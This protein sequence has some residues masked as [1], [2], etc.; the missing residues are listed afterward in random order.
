MSFSWRSLT[1]HG[2]IKI[3]S[4]IEVEHN[5]SM[6]FEIQSVGGGI[7][8]KIKNREKSW[9][10]TGEVYRSLSIYKWIQEYRTMLGS[11]LCVLHSHNIKYG[12]HAAHVEIPTL[13]VRANTQSR[14]SYVHDNIVIHGWISGN[15]RFGEIC[16]GRCVRCDILII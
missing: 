11:G 12:R 9:A 15:K 7:K 13:V 8:L 1:P 16:C 3:S 5:T 4:H 2:R 14:I 6:T 10:L